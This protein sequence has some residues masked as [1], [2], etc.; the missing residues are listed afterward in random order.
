MALNIPAPTVDNCTVNCEENPPGGKLPVPDQT[1]IANQPLLNPNLTPEDRFTSSFSD[2]LGIFSPARKNEDDA[3]TLAGK[4]EKATGAKPAFIYASFVPADLTT[5]KPG[6]I[7]PQDSD[8][9]ELLIV[10]AKGEPLR[11]RISTATRAKVLQVADEFR[12]E[13][14]NQRNLGTDTYLQLAQQL[15]GWLIAPVDAELQARGINNLVFLPDAGLRS[16]PIA[17]LHD[18]R[19]YL[20]ERYSVGLMPSLSLT[21]TLITDIKDSQL[22]AMGVSQSTQG[23]TP[24]PAVPVELSTLVAKLWRGQLVLD[25]QSTLETLKTLRGQQRYGIIHMAT[26]ASF[27]A[28]PIGESYIQLWE[29]KLRLDQIRQLGLNDPQVEMLVLSACKTALGDEEAELG[30]AGLA[31]LSGVKTTVASLWSVNDAGTAALI[32]KF[33]ENL[34][35]SPIKSEA[36]RRAQLAMIKGEVFL[37]DGRIQGLGTIEGVPL[38]DASI[39]EV[40]E[41]LSHPYYWAGF[42]MVGNPW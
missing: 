13:L 1:S 26:H 36:L 2:H 20:V 17:A 33:Y 9:L 28:G 37:K 29:D 32:I 23:Q 5:D 25:N 19:G 34:K 4:V 41:A 42:T 39:A 8:Q 7:A 27:N 16:T 21:N 6:T 31:V 24:L 14:I 38:P 11:R 10:T 3:Q 40:D 18:G 15:Y 12:N 30:F 35:T 22:L